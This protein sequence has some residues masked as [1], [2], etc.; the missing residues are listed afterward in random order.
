MNSARF[1]PT[2]SG[3]INL[4]DYRDQEF[5]FADGRLV[6]RGPNG[7][8]KTKALEVLF[9]FVFD[10]RIEPRRLNPFA[11]E[12]RTMKS[13]LLYRGQDT[14]HSY[15]WMEFCRGSLD[16]PEAVTVGIGMRASRTNDKVT[17]WYFVADG[18]VGVD[19]SL[20]G[21][22]D[23]PLTKKQLAEQLGSDAITD[24]PLDYRTAIDARMFGLGVQRYDQL[25]NLILTLRRPQLAKNLDPKGL[26]QALTDGL[27][28]LDDQLVL[29]AARSFSDMEEVG[30]AL[31]GLAAAD[32]A[33]Q[34]FIGVYTKYLRQQ[35]RGEIEQVGARLAAVAK[36]VAAMD[37][38]AVAQLRSREA[39]TAA[40]ERF[41]AAEQALDHARA[42]V[43]ALQR[44]S[45]YEGKQQ[46]DD[47]AQA[48]ATLKLSTEQQADKSRKAQATL[49]QRGDEAEKATA[50]VRRGAEALSRAEDELRV[51][52]E[53]AGIVWTPLP[54]GSRSDQITAAVRGHAE[55][56]DG[57]VRVVRAALATVEKA[58]TERTRAENSSRRG[59]E[60]LESAKAAVLE[61]EA[62][63]ELARS[64]CATGLRSWWTGHSERYAAAGADTSLF[65]AL[66]GALSAVGDEDAP[67]LAAV[68]AEH[69]EAGIEA[70]RERRRSAEAE[71]SA[72]RASVTAL[73]AERKAVSAE[74]DDAPPA[75]HA[76][77]DSRK[78]LPGAPFWSLVRFAESVEP[79]VATGIE[80]A[81]Q[82][83]NMLDGWVVPGEQLPEFVSEQFLTAFPTK[84]RPKGRTLADVLEVE[85]N[86]DVPDAQVRGILASISLVENA[87]TT[88]A[89]VAIGVDGRFWQGVVHGRHVKTDAEYI[90]TTA[91][92]R[93]RAARIAE[94]DVALDELATAIDTGTALVAQTNEQLAQLAA[95]AKEL[96][97]TGSILRA[98]KAVAESAGALRTRSEATDSAQREL[99]AAI[100]DL[101][102]KEKQLRATASTH[103]TPHAGRELD[104]LAA[105]IRHFE[106]QGDVAL[107]CRREYAK[108]VELERESIDRLDE[109][110]TNAEEFAEEA[111]IAEESLLQQVQ[112]LETLRDTL[113]ASAEQ[114]D[115]DLAKAR[116]KIEECKVDQRAARKAYDAAVLHIGTAEGAYNTAVETL[117]HTLTETRS[118]AEQLAPYA[119]PDLLELL[120]ITEPL[121]WP[122]SSAAWMSPDQLVYRIQNEDRTD[123]APHPPVLPEDVDKLYRALD[124][125]TSTVRVT[126]GARKATRTALTSALQEFDAQLAA[127]GQDYRLQW[128]APDGLTVVRVQDEQGHS[129]IGEFATRI[130]EARGDQE[131][132]L[133]ES[134]RRIL[135]DALLTGLAQQI[136]ERTVDA[137]E[138]I[139]Q[140]GTEMRERHMSSGNTIGVHWVLADNLDD[141]SRAISKLLDRDASALGVDELATLRA[142]FATQIRTA[143]AAHPERS[144]PEILSSALDYR[145][146][147]FFSFTLISG[148]GK[149]DRLTVARHSALSGGEQSVSLHLPL[150]AAAHVMLDS[151]DPHAPRLLALDEAFAGV[152]DNGRSELLGLS[153]QFDL[154]L[155]MTGYDLWITYADVPGC[156][157]YDL[158]HS[159]AEQAVSAALLVWSNGELLAEH[160][161]TDLARALG[162]PLRRRVPTPAEG[163]LDYA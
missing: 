125:A 117:R 19:F 92:A 53:D 160:D 143:R 136:H 157:H 109:S 25:I 8:G 145:Q 58:T 127:A 43:E 24:R 116:A 120:G 72:A 113:G 44:S 22:D 66:D 133:T 6:L 60:L 140:M 38:S 28:P 62:A 95:A 59:Q 148:E 27:R 134:E 147:R 132:L 114:I 91:R 26:S 37:E 101:A 105:A 118:D 78:D 90:G 32:G 23:R 85:G 161:G 12:E 1:R 49:A 119:R 139:A 31:E 154:D 54:E 96:P 158:A 39:R 83:A 17:R 124:A 45:A 7:S 110:R 40:E 141:S 11:G 71:I 98:L 126:D 102:A 65:E 123:D 104:S 10:G 144:Y 56:R 34:T 51:A 122:A 100:A 20:I 94:I 159:T 156:A 80:S 30:R 75:F 107:R 76:R 14:A 162:S 68:L 48:V 97:K 153:V 2:R 121:S 142:H 35:S 150:F 152:D 163:A 77:T 137:R 106:K 70:L 149:E 74:H 138:L 67:T 33:A 81:L 29:E 21:A 130:H 115:L 151:A 55:E 82:A 103:R 64:E 4:W 87:D 57:D 61:G 128:D 73:K 84:Q 69:T 41:N 9:P 42:N 89:A 15:V 50:S 36:G 5:S 146:W 112:R 131:Q 47:L 108:E 93:R 99:D 88:T 18:R 155:F 13:N 135:E 63:V 16:D 3:I 86:S 111:A 129:S 52:A 46:L 79:D